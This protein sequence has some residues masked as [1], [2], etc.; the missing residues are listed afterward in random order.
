MRNC[1]LGLLP[2]SNHEVRR[3]FDLPVHRPGDA[4]ADADL[5]LESGDDQQVAVGGDRV[6]PEQPERLHLNK[7]LLQDADKGTVAGFGFVDAMF[8]VSLK[9]IRLERF[10]I[11]H[12]QQGAGKGDFAAK[13]DPLPLERKPVC[14]HAQEH[15]FRLHQLV[16]GDD[17]RSFAF[18]GEDDEI[19]GRAE[20]VLG[21]D[22]LGRR[23]VADVIDESKVDLP[24]VRLVLVQQVN[25]PTVDVG[26]FLIV[27]RD[28][29]LVGQRVKN[30]DCA[31]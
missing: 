3:L 31:G 28:L 30:A 10:G 25:Q 19:G 26:V 15:Q 1:V 17:P 9:E 2:A 13:S 21:A 27:K 16:A 8:A 5:E 24:A 11:G 22:L 23:G 12:S 20:I 6:G 14:L 4:E 18:A 7:I 29:N